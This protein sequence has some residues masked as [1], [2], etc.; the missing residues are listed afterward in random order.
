VIV[1]EGLRVFCLA[2]LAISPATAQDI[3]PADEREIASA[4]VGCWEREEPVGS[5][6]RLKM[7]FGPEDQVT[8]AWAAKR[9]N[10]PEITGKT[11]RTFGVT[12]GKLWIV[13]GRD[14]TIGAVSSE[15]ACDVVMR[16]GVAMRLENCITTNDF[17]TDVIAEPANGSVSFSRVKG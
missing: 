12:N 4:L 8:T 11:L 2:A 14:A 5:Y 3:R 10:T 9:P 17:G 7:C 6:Y 16:L 13:G 15:E 1:V